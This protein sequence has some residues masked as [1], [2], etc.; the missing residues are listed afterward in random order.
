MGYMHMMQRSPVQY[1]MTF[2]SKP[3]KPPTSLL[4]INISAFISDTPAFDWCSI[5]QCLW[6]QRTK[7]YAFVF[8]RMSYHSQYYSLYNCPNMYITAVCYQKYISHNGWILNITKAI[9]C[10]FVII[11]QWP[12]TY[13][14]R[15]HPT[16][17]MCPDLLGAKCPDLLQHP[18]WTQCLIWQ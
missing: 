11:C 17:Y 4:E 14:T 12:T 10:V 7:Q 18:A 6:A 13:S 5:G 15:H 9:H 3:L 2:A 16:Y 8:I 1:L